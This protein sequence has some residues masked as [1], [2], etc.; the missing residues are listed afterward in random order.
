MATQHREV[1]G[2]V[3]QIEDS[4]DAIRFSLSHHSGKPR[5]PYSTIN[6]EKAHGNSY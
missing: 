1:G 3:L 4:I 2:S 6:W 5:L